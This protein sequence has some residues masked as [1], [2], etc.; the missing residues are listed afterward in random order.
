MDK[1]RKRI[2][3]VNVVLILAAFIVPGREGVVLGM[4]LAIGL[5]FINLL[6]AVIILFR[7]LSV[8]ELEPRLFSLAGTF[9]LSTLVVLMV[10]VPVCGV[11]AAFG[12][13]ST[14]FGELLNR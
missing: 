14:G 4:A 13:R 10:S 6:I 1:M 11:V 8:P 7:S 12:L 9:G 3:A 2:L 5:A